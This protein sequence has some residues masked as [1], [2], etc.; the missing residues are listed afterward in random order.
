MLPDWVTNQAQTGRFINYTPA[1]PG[2]YAFTADG[3]AKGMGSAEQL[4]LLAL[5]EA[6]FSSVLD[7]GP[8]YER[9][10]STIAA[11][12]LAPLVKQQIIQFVAIQVTDAPSNQ[13]GSICQITWKDLTT[14]QEQTTTV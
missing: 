7:K 11:N 2:D 9:Q 1:G 14:G 6:P 12:A 4:V 5:T 8:N 13:D 10:I 3:R